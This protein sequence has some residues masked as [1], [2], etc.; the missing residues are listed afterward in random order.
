MFFAGHLPKTLVTSVACVLAIVVL[1]YSTRSLAEEPPLTTPEGATAATVDEPPSFVVPAGA[2]LK[3]LL[4][5]KSRL[6]SYEPKTAE[7]NR[8]RQEAMLRTCDAILALPEVQDPAKGDG[9]VMPI[10][11]H[12][13]VAVLDK[14]EIWEEQGSRDGNETARRAAEAFAKSLTNDA[15][16]NVKF[17]AEAELLK[18]ALASAA[19]SK[20]QR[21][22]AADDALAFF[23]AR[24]DQAAVGLH[25]LRAAQLVQKRYPPEE[26][27]DFYDRL[28]RLVVTSSLK[29]NA[30]WGDEFIKQAPGGSG[31]CRNPWN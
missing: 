12:A 8:L 24:L 15:R 31:C 6:W 2:G 7:R 27:V 30:H 26:T 20:P 18:Q 25:V 4:D 14:F 17:Q 10:D 28:G 19:E 5:L 21:L 13:Y 22:K 23:R 29:T 1:V 3:E 16:P 9:Q 11:G